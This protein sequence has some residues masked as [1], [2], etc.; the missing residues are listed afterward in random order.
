MI[1]S[2]IT[3]LSIDNPHAVAV[4]NGIAIKPIPVRLT[5]MELDVVAITTNVSNDFSIVAFVLNFFIFL[6]GFVV[7]IFEVCNHLFD[8]T[9]MVI[10]TVF[11]L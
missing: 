3:L 10:K 6:F 2:Y 5:V 11:I 4:N 9:D 7:F 1:I 8:V